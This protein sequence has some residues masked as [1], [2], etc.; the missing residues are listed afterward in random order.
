MRAFIHFYDGGVN[1]SDRYSTRGKIAPFHVMET[2]NSA[3]AHE[4]AGNRVLHLEVGQPSTAAPAQ[5]LA[6]AKH[7]LDTDVLGYTERARVCLS[8]GPGSH[9]GTRSD[10][11]S[12]LI[13]VE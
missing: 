3:A 11:T 10:T 2:M 4:R 5:V 6:A 9:S 7:A 12:I 8:F 1:P 13:R